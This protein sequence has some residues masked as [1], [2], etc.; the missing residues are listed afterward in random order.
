MTA[1][2]GLLILC[3][4]EPETNEYLAEAVTLTLWCLSTGN[5]K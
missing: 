5:C 4:S 3:N 1:I 2:I